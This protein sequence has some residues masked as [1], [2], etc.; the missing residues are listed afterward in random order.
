ML[1]TLSRNITDEY[2]GGEYIG[3]LKL[4]SKLGINPILFFHILI[5]LLSFGTFPT[6]WAVGYTLQICPWELYHRVKIRWIFIFVW[7]SKFSI[8]I[9]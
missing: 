9:I 7:Y 4:N 2:N 1:C 3:F 8:K 5:Y 6:S